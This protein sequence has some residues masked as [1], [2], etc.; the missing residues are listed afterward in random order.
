MVNTRKNQRKEIAIMIKPTLM[1]MTL[2]VCILFASAAFA[3]KSNETDG[4]TRERINRA[5]ISAVS[6]RGEVSTGEITWN[7]LAVE[8]AGSVLTEINTGA[9]LETK[10]K[11][12]TI[13]F[14]VENQ[15][16][17]TEYI[18]DLRVVDSRGR[19]Y[20]ICV[21]AYAYLGMTDACML[22]ELLPNIER[23]F[24]MTHDLPANA[25]DLWLEV[26]DLN[27]PPKEKK[28]I[29]LGL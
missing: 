9:T 23:T 13:R 14:E 20:P 17:D 18:Y 4:V 2:V 7:I 26:T 3:A 29:D 22:T 6:K 25:Q 11:F 24:T 21:T 12:I 27:V 19:T 15:G 5:D 8:E 28:Y 10:G 1:I 16:E